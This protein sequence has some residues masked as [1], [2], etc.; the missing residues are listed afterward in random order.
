MVR[1]ES[2]GEKIKEGKKNVIGT[3]PK[4][5]KPHSLSSDKKRSL[6]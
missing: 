6:R 3:K 1:H 5:S 2:R 4:V